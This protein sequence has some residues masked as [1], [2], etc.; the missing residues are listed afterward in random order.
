MSSPN[1]RQAKFSGRFYPADREGLKDQINGFLDGFL[2]DKKEALA[3][4]LPHAGYAYSGKVCAQTLAS[5][6][7]SRVKTVVLLGPNHTGRGVAWSIMPKGAWQTA[8]GQAEIDEEFSGRLIKEADFLQPDCLAHESEH[9]IEVQLPMLQY[10]KS[11]F[12]I[13]PICIGIQDI[14]NLLCLGEAIAHAAEESKPPGSLLLAVS[15]DM[16][17]YEPQA[18]AKEKDKAAIKAI[19]NMD[20]EGLIQAVTTLDISM[21]GFG[22]AVAMLSYAKASG[23]KSAQLIKYQTSGDVSGDKDAVV[24]Y[25][26]ITIS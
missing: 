21:C 13:V 17:H 2:A 9:S 10:F 19:L 6:D 24:G 20:I 26:G 18:R 5:I 3:C 22:P 7:L 11:D 14:T 23:A 1:L 15:S 8:L 4:M 16:T 25:A 12:S